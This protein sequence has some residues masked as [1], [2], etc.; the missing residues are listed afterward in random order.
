M[1][2]CRPFTLFKPNTQW[3][4]PP[5]LD[6]LNLI[7]N[8]YVAP[9]PLQYS[10]LIHNI[11]VPF[12]Y[13]IQ[14]R[15]TTFM[16]LSLTISK[17]DTQHSCPRPL[18]YPNPIHNIHVPFPYNIQTQYTTFMSPYL[19]YPN[20]I[21][22]IYVLVPYNIQTQYTTFMSP[23]SSLM[24]FKMNLLFK[25]LLDHKFAKKRLIKSCTYRKEI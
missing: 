24:S 16:S 10:N 8:I 20:P 25:N 18:Q 1:L 19:K 17:P 22:D 7:H 5:S 21:H 2:L 3:Y 23:F 13:N 14:T 15:Y 11:H 6:Y 4:Y 9:R 12:P